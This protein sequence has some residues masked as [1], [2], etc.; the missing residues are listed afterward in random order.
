MALD[1]YGHAGIQI[2]AVL[3]VSALYIVSID[4]G[5]AFVEDIIRVGWHHGCSV[6][7]ETPRRLMSSPTLSSWTPP[8]LPTALAFLLIALLIVFMV[9]NK[10]LKRTIRRNTTK[11]DAPAWSTLNEEYHEENSLTLDLDGWNRFNLGNLTRFVPFWWD[12]GGFHLNERYTSA[13]ELFVA[14]CC[15]TT[16]AAVESKRFSTVKKGFFCVS[17]QFRDLYGELANR[18]VDGYGHLNSKTRASR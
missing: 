14:E 18:F 11:E 6:V 1:Y 16:L 17:T 9:G 15:T 8:L 13:L 7:Y 2:V 5:A 4:G 10:R 3:V 12:Q